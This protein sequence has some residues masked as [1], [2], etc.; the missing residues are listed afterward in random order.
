MGAK[1]LLTRMRRA[2]QLVAI[3][4]LVCALLEEVQSLEGEQEQRAQP[5]DGGEVEAGFY[6]AVKAYEIFLIRRALLKARGNQALA[7]RLLGLKPTTL[8]Y[9]LKAYDIKADPDAAARANGAAAGSCADA[10][11]RQPGAS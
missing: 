11:A 6:E 1:S 4:E 2:D 9:K 7:A 3:R 5:G 10:C 8:F